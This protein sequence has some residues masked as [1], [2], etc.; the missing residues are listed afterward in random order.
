MDQ[1]IYTNTMR[2]EQIAAIVG[3]RSKGV[4]DRLK[5]QIAFLEIQKQKLKQENN[6]RHAL[7]IQSIKKKQRAILMKLEYIKNSLK[8]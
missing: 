6:V 7:E 2:S 4:V 8:K 1:M 3:A 5:C